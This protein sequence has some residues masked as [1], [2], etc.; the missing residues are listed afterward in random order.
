MYIK[1]LLWAFVVEWL[2]SDT[3]L[4]CS[5]ESLHGDYEVSIFR[6]NLSNERQDTA[7]KAHY[8]PSNVP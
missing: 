8:S 1:Q 3:S 6:K 4:N 2:K 5:N 7:K